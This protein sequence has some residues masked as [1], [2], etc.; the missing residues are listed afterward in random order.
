MTAAL[1]A[2]NWAV[3]RRRR[4]RLWCDCQGVVRGVRRLLHGHAVKRNRSH[5]DLWGQIQQL[6]Q[7][8]PGLIQIQKVVSHGSLQ[9]ATGPLEDWVYWHNH[10]TDLAAEQANLHRSEE[11]WQLWTGLR[12]ALDFHRKLHGAILQTLLQTS[13]MA[14]AEQPVVQ[15]PRVIEE[16]SPVIQVPSEWQVVPKVLKR[17]GRVNADHLHTW[18]LAEGLDMLQ[19]S[20]PIVL[21]SGIQL[22]FAFNLCT[23]YLGP[24]CHRKR[25][26]STADQAPASARQSWGAR[27]KLFLMMLGT[28]WKSNALVVPH[29]LARPASAAI[30]KWVVSYRLRWDQSKI[31]IIDGLILS[32]L[33]RQAVTQGD[34]ARLT[35]AKTG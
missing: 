26:Y 31:D 2:I 34:L 5:S 1:Q 12:T 6:L 15:I 10:L 30:A 3:K 18:W 33:G 9:A 24:W 28:Y 27:C 22:Y 21:I 25:W 35:A 11:F 17:Y 7:E 32:Q 14:A 29:K 8:G 19:G 23:G 20:S 16:P 13:R 4:V